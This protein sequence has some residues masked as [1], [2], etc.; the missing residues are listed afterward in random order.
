M[1]PVTELVQSLNMDVL[2]IGG[3]ARE[4]ALAW[5]I[6]QSPRIGKLYIAP[7]NGGTEK[8]GENVP[9]IA[10]DF[11]KL[12]RFAVE[13]QIGLT[14]VGPDLPLALG[15]VDYFKD[16]GLHIWGPTKA[17][18]KIESSKV[19]AK[20]LMHE[21]KIPTAE[22]DVASDFNSAIAYVR[23][24][25][26]PLVVKASGLADGKGVY[27]CQTFEEAEAALKEIMIDKV[28]GEA[29]AEIVIEEFLEGEEMS[30]HALCDGINFILFPASQDYK[31]ALDGDQGKNTGG[32]GAIVPVPWVTGEMMTTIEL[33]IIRPTLE[34]LARLGSPFTGILYPG[35]KVSGTGI[36]VL[37]FNAR[38]GDPETQA[39][40]RILGTDL[41]D[42]IEASLDGTLGNQKIE[43]H[44]G[45][46]SNV[47]LASRGYPEPNQDRLPITGIED[48]ERNENI[49]VFHAGTTF[50][51][52]LKT[53]GGRVLSV[54]ALGS[55]LKQSLDLAYEAV[56]K[57]EFE[58]MQYRK[59][60]GAKSL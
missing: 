6:A 42:L 56:K 14:V 43:W 1:V 60:I 31:R 48:A 46:A 2:V 55:P 10:T 21:A 17:A 39:Y 51:G 24:R 38:F 32:M 15:I 58:G 50:D 36:K 18:A 54:T 57:I 20:K 44:H 25:G 16:R 12:A 27:V 4:H 52:Q 34:A 9:I 13:K 35:L 33:H 22:F 59:D 11:E 28:H 26:V 47:V 5:K 37:E 7:G 49:V 41:L 19:F 40:M 29:G 30:I 8:V 3:G 45:F 53:A 23:R